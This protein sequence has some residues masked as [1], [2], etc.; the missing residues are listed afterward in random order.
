M[1]VL[2]LVVPMA[3]VIVLAAIVAFVWSARHGQFDDLDTPALRVLH[4][5][6]APGPSKVPPAPADCVE[7]PT[8]P[9]DRAGNS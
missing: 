1:S 6:A 7:R 2:F 8:D 5:D 9:G 3:M 4:D